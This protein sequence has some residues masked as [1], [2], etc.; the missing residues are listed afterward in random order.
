[1]LPRSQLAVYLLVAVVAV[2][3]LLNRL[4]PHH[5]HF[6]HGLLV[7]HD[8]V[9]HLLH[10]GEEK[11]RQSGLQ[12]AKPATE[13]HNLVVEPTA[14]SAAIQNTGY[15]NYRSQRAALLLD[16]ILSLLRSNRSITC[17]FL[18]EAPWY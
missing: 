13:A 7:L 6:L 9:V 11:Q 1:M 16:Q 18:R 10:L 17:W 12:A 14:A 5:L 3:V 8:H 2:L 4:L 15:D